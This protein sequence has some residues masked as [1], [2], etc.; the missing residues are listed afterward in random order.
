MGIAIGLVKQARGLPFTMAQAMVKT[1]SSLVKSSSLFY[2]GMP[3]RYENHHRPGNSQAKLLSSPASHT[4][5]GTITAIGLIMQ[6]LEQL[7]A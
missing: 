2:L 5:A 6:E 7:Q 4:G 1:Q 3:Y